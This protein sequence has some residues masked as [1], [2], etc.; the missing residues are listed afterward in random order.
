MGR[1]LKRVPMD[2]D[3][4]LREVWKG[5]LMPDR[6][7]EPRCADCKNGYSR[8]GQ[9]LMDLW[10][11]NAPFGPADTGSTPFTV[12][13]PAV[14]D[15]AQRHV[16]QASDFYGSGEAAVVREAR[17][18]AS[19]YNGC[20]CHHLDQGDVD[21]L[22]EAGRLRDFTHTF[23]RGEGWQKIEPPVIPTAAEVNE[24]SLRGFGHDSISASV[25]VRARCKREGVADTCQTC[26]G[27]ATVEAYEGQRAEVEAWEWTEP[28]EGDGYQ[29][30]ET[31]SEGSPIS[32]VF[33]TLD[34]LC[35][36]AAANCTTFGS[37]TASAEGWHKMLDDD[38][39]AAT[40]ITSDGSTAIF[41]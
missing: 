14:R 7:I 40:S 36:Y 17:R 31:T 29:I 32:P 28:P 6:L 25:V 16:G 24:W 37:S 18:L 13:T 23:R 4:P 35:E 3:A 39:V 5:Y 11:G 21:A 30:W 34:E 1:T 33:A 19:L 10:Y 15:L 20:W 38:V 2:F 41:M 22:V 27:H 9:E 26:D 8:R 12:D